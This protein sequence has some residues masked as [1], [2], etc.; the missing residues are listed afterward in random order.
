MGKTELLKW[1]SILANEQSVFLWGHQTQCGK[2][3]LFHMCKYVIRKLQNW[4]LVIT[5]NNS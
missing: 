1:Y 5:S 2:D 4:V 3:E